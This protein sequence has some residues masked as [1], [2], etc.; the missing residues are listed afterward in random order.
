VLLGALVWAAT[1]TAESSN[2]EN[3]GAFNFI[4]VHPLRIVSFTYR[5]LGLTPRRWNPV[6]S[7]GGWRVYRTANF[8]S[9]CKN[10]RRELL[11]RTSGLLP[12]KLFGGK[13]WNSAFFAKIFNHRGH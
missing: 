7:L 10:Y 5:N 3:N 4:A 11:V 8:P 9:G 6:E 1:Q 13:L 2:I 12:V